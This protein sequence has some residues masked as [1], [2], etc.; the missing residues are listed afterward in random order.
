M[1]PAPKIHSF[2][3][4]SG[5][6]VMA[7][8]LSGV[9]MYAVHFP[10]ISRLSESEYGVFTTL[11]TILNIMLIPALGLQTVFTQQSAAAL[12]EEERRK[13]AGTVRAVLCLTFFIWLAVGLPV[14]FWSPQISAWL[15]IS[16]PAAL[17]LTVLVGL[18]ML[19][20]PI[21]LGLLQG[22]QNFLWLGWAAILNAAGRFT[23]AALL[24]Y[25]FHGRSASLMAAALFGLTVGLSLGA[26]HSRAMWR[27]PRAPFE[28][29]WWWRRIVPLTLGLGS[30]QF[31]FSA[32]ML[33]VRALFDKDATGL[34]G[35][36]GTIGRGLVTFTAPVVAVMFPK[37]VR[38]AALSEKTDVLAKGLL[39]TAFLGAVG[40]LACTLFP[41][42]PI[43][44]ANKP[45]YLPIVP[46]IRWFAWCMVPLAVANVVIGNLLARDR[47]SVVPWLILVAAGYGGCLCL[48]G[49]YLL[50]LP[51]FTAFKRVV[52]MLGLF[53]LLLL[54][55]AITFTWRGA[56]A[57]KLKP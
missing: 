51:T 29:Q 46:L 34:Y 9:F 37:I 40:A 33:V 31:I 56:R 44:I 26:W 21:V 53:N 20:Q 6:M 42:L 25:V 30:A 3:R 19:W 49:D 48:A 57:H 12:R 11:L 50:S 27:K 47:F 4:Q 35:A 13:L 17:G 18:P 28:W 39:A 2:F 41:T 32:D 23:L 5:W 7:T 55:V 1:T 22:S 38:S 52:Q 10:A 36:A 54:L 43:K 24:I 16:R 15:N 45:S 8:T 14:V